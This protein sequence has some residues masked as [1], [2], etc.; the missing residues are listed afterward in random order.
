LGT[1]TGINFISVS[2]T[3][4][5][6]K[7]NK[8][9]KLPKDGIPVDIGVKSKNS[10]DLDKKKLVTT[11]SAV[12]FIKTKPP[13]FVMKVSV[14]GIFIGNN[15]DDLKK[16]SKVHAPAHLMPFIREIVG[17]TTM[18]AGIPPLL[19]PPMNLSALFDEKKK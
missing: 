18:K 6:F 11:L 14:E 4:L 13:P 16:F 17:T 10:F 5:D 2:L 8:K 19:L 12:L 7:L 3:E 15:I 9:F 1:E